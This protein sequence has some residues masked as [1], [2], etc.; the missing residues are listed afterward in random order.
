[1][2][3]HRLFRKLTDAIRLQVITWTNVEQELRREMRKL[4]HSVLY[5]QSYFEIDRPV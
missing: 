4:H 1:M 5:I 2:I 3:N